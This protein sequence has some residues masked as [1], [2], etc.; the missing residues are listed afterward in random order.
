MSLSLIPRTNGED[1]FVLV[2]CNL[3]GDIVCSSPIP[4]NATKL[5]W[6]NISQIAIA[7]SA[8]LGEISQVDTFHKVLSEW[9]AI[10]DFI[11]MSG[12]DTK[13]CEILIKVDKEHFRPHGV[14]AA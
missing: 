4:T 8:T 12:T 11:S 7:P 1:A 6:N 9:F 10:V 2:I 5:V 14:H 13:T 3:L